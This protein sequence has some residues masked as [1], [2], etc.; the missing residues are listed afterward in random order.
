MVYRRLKI[1]NFRCIEDADVNLD[2]R[3][4]MIVGDNGA[5]K[6]SLLEAAY[7]LGR[8]RSFRQPR[9]DR[10]IRHGQPAFQLFGEIRQRD[11]LH[12]VGIEGARGGHRVRID[13][14][15]KPNLA[16]VA[17][18]L[19]IQ[20][21]EPEIHTLVAEGPERRRKFLDY[22][23]FHVEPG[24]LAA[25]RRYR[26]ALKQRSAGLR[27]GHSLK[28]L[29][30]WDSELI[31]SGELVDSL[32]SGYVQMLRGPVAE[33]CDA[34][35]L[36]GID[37]EYRPGWDDALSMR[38][39]LD[40]SFARD[41]SQHVTGVGPHRADLRITWDKRAAKT[42]VSRGQQKLLAAGLVL[43]QTRLLAGLNEDEVVLLVDDPAA[44]LDRTSL[45]RLMAQIRELPGQLIM[46]AIDPDLAGMPADAAVFHVE[47]GVITG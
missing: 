18:Q 39:A 46:T 11:R 13:G 6:T 20:V 10:L 35:G 33:A 14:E 17:E 3:V 15:E 42:Q 5:G 22:G 44:E 8:G 25:W 41:A 27:Q 45:A 47:R 32:R 2:Q 4:S 21:I 30:P 31:Q 12:R 1:T 19:V 29:A 26:K 34:L 24:Y 28:Q 40:R 16:S 43:A 23:V 37:I 38:E 9:T 7:F 36:G